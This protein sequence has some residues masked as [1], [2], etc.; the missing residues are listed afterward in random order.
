MFDVEFIS[1]VEVKIS[2]DRVL[3]ENFSYRPVSRGRYVSLILSNE[4]RTYKE[5]IKSQC[6]DSDF[7]DYVRSLRDTH[8]DIIV[9]SSYEFLIPFHSFFTKAGDL[10]RC[11]VTNMVKTVEDSMIGEVLDDRYV[12]ENVVK[13]SPVLGISY[14]INACYMFYKFFPSNNLELSDG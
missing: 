10:T 2:V 11:D 14:Y 6:E 9:K 7:H 5:L 1:C 12:V 3:S 13:K 8:P 4:A